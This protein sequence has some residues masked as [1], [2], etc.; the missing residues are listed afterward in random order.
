[1]SHDM[2][3]YIYPNTSSDDNLASDVEPVI[4]STLDNVINNTSVSSRLVDIDY[5]HPNRDDSSTS[6]FYSSWET[7]VKNNLSRYGCHLCVSTN[8]ASGKAAGGNIFGT[9]DDAFV[10]ESWAVAGE[11]SSTAASKNLWIQEVLHTFINANLSRYDQEGS[12]E[13]NLGST[14]FYEDVTPM[15]ASYE[16]TAA[17]TGYCADPNW[18]G[19]YTTTLT[20]CTQRGIDATFESGFNEGSGT[21]GTW[22][23]AKQI[24]IDEPWQ[25]YNISPTLPYPVVLAKPISYTGSQPAHSRIQ[26]VPRSA[27]DF[28]CRVEEWEYQNGQHYDETV[29]SLV[30]NTGRVREDN[31][32]KYIDVGLLDGVDETFVVTGY[33]GNYFNEPIVITQA[34]TTNGDQSIVTRVKNVTT[35][36]FEVRVQEEE[37]LGGHVGETVGWLATPPNTGYLDGWQYEAGRVTGIDHTWTTISFSNS[38]T[39][40]V[41]LAD[42]QTFNG[43]D[44]AGLRHRNLTGTS[45]EIKVEEEQSSTTEMDHTKAEEVGY[46]VIE[47]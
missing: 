33:H 8:I 10:S 3:V 19:G 45:V 36:T 39:N 14:D 6:A 42:M 4:Q 44:P 1:M 13:H 25:S 28:E 41:F 15:A 20:S 29:G 18:D 22:F 37:A 24:T 12:N 43:S 9:S 30:I 26:S 34:Q 21:A 27:P 11:K 17:E 2:R 46:L 7:Y 47:S 31:P 23:Q 32:G 16:D 38:Y 40:P 35:D 5:L